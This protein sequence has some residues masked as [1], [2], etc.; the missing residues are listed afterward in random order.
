L[1]AFFGV[2]MGQGTLSFS[3]KAQT[4]YFNF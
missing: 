1:R 2:G 3:N 4:R